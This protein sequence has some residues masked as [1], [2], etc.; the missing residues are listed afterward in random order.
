MTDR[1]TDQLFINKIY[2]V[3]GVHYFNDN[4]SQ[5]LKDVIKELY[6]S[7]QDLICNLR[8]N[9][10]DRAICK[11]RQAKE[12]TC[13][14]NTRQYFKSCIVSAIVETGLDELEPMDD[15]EWV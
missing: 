7:H 11:Y 14:W 13:I 10:I 9:H 1:L 3:S 6:Y 2:E 12:K 5:I 4:I 8:L 15:K